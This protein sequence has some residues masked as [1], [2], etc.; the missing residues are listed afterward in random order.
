MPRAR[1]HLGA[2]VISRRCDYACAALTNVTTRRSHPA[3]TVPAAYA[4][5]VTKAPRL[6]RSGFLC[7]VPLDFRVKDCQATSSLLVPKC[8]EDFRQ[9]FAAKKKS[10][11]LTLDEETLGILAVSFESEPDSVAFDMERYVGGLYRS[12]SKG[13]GNR[14]GDFGEF[15]VYLLYRRAGRN[16]V[17]V[18]GSVLPPGTAMKGKRFP[19]PDFLV[20]GNLGQL[21]ALEV[22]T[23]EALDYQTLFRAPH[24]QLAPCREVER[25]RREALP[26]L[27]YDSRGKKLDA[28]VH[29]L[30]L[31]SGGTNPFPVDEGEAAAVL[32]LDGRALTMRDAPKLKTPGHC[33][34][35][36]RNC[37]ECIAP[38][39]GPVHVTVVR[40]HNE[41]GRLRLLGSHGAGLQWLHRYERWV[42]A[43]WARD[44]RATAGALRDLERTTD[45]WVASAVS[46][47]QGETWSKVRTRAVERARDSVRLHWS[48]YLTECLLERGLGSAA[49][50][51]SLPVPEWN[52]DERARRRREPESIA[53]A[54]KAAPSAYIERGAARVSIGSDVPSEREAQGTMSL[55]NDEHHW[56]LRACSGPWWSRLNMDGATPLG[57][58]EARRAAHDA[59]VGALTVKNQ[60]HT[61][62]PPLEPP[63]L[64]SVTVQVGNHT[65]LLGWRPLSIMEG[66]KWS[67]RRGGPF[68]LRWLRLGDTRAQLFVLP[69]GRVHLR[70][71]LGGDR[72]G[73]PS[74]A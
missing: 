9:E 31:T 3:H 32:A 25:L 27:G 52:A 5:R 12:K 17:K 59:I 24:K 51:E 4:F 13:P 8:D 42:A 61:I 7:E 70:A 35:V 74:G 48:T 29:A 53:L 14:L 65:E 58:A 63:H 15:V 46:L 16:P 28:Y 34:N 60:L 26:Q 64:K 30:K 43:T 37:W 2:L 11:P 36:G 21:N 22:K 33:K 69:D 47:P 18:I 10:L 57:E 55:T 67:P 49:H 6:V 50:F 71:L 41:R 20:E 19:Q 66:G 38:S 56:V 73:L 23:T 72:T 68:W 44:V 45:E 54:W 62:D 1:G 39:D 40:M